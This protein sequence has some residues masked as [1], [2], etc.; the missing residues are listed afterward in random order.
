VTRAG[1]PTAALPIGDDAIESIRLPEDVLDLNLSTLRLG[2]FMGLTPVVLGFKV[3]SAI[4]G[5]V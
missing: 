3:E 4:F 2:E 1:E 5:A